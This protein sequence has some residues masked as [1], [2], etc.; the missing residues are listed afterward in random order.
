MP[1]PISVTISIPNLA[2]NLAVVRRHVDRATHALHARPPAIWAVIKA[3]AYGHGIENAVE[4]FSA[5]Q[6]M[7]LLDFNEAVR[8]REAGW[9][10]PILMLEGCFEWADLELVDRYQLAITVHCREQLDM[11]EQAR[12]SQRVN[13]MVKMN[14]GM[15]RLG[16]L[17]AAY[18]PA[19]TRV[20]RL[21]EQ[22][23]IGT[24]GKMTHFATADGTGGVS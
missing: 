11:L 21:Q 18:A 12:L 8:C 4:G 23:I 9:R 14:S 22:G 13:V 1:R 20:Q 19:Y 10:G 15:N 7:A 16:F 24:L 5:A 6:G 3:N 2:H 17:P